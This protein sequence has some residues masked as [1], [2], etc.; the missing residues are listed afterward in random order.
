[1][2][3]KKKDTSKRNPERKKSGGATAK[4]SS[5]GRKNTRNS[6]HNRRKQQP[7][8]KGGGRHGRKPAHKQQNK[9]AQKKYDQ[10]SGQ[11]Q[12]RDEKNKSQKSGQPRQ[13]KTAD[14]KKILQDFT[15]RRINKAMA[16]GSDEKSD[17]TITA[18]IDKVDDIMNNDFFVPI[19]SRILVAVSGGV[20]SV[21]LLDILAQM[22]EK[23]NFELIVC[24][25]NH[26]LRGK[27][28]DE[29]EKYVARL[30]K[31]YGLQFL[32][33]Q[34]NV[35]K[36]AEKYSLGIE[37]A[38]RR[39]RY[40]FLDKTARSG[41]VDY[42][43]TAHNA[44]DTVE[45]FLLNLFRGAGLTGLS[46]IPEMRQIAKNLALI[47]PLSRM[48]RAEI[49]EYA[50]L[51]SLEWREDA[52]NALLIYS[53]NRIRHDLLPKL[54]KEYSPAVVDVIK[55]TA[56]LFRN[57]DEFIADYVKMGVNRVIT[58]KG[59]D[60]FAIKIGFFQTYNEFI[61][62]EI[63]QSAMRK[64]FNQQPVSLKTID[65]ILDLMSSPVG[66]ICEISRDFIVL[67]D[68]DKLIFSR[69]KP[70]FECDM[71]ID[72]IGIF[73]VGKQ[74]IIL[75]KVYKKDVK[76][77]RDPNIEYFDMDKLPKLLH[78]RRWQPGDSF[79]PV[80]FE[81]HVKVGDYLT[82]QKVSLL[83]KQNVLVLTN[84]VDIIWV[85]GFRMSD[86]YKV[87]KSTQRVIKAE[88][89]DNAAEKK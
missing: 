77:T 47:R 51:R 24:H 25:F 18:A 74:K 20:D 33:G 34:G 68:R 88:F 27:E 14:P 23:F 54:E 81:G 58:D 32:S 6:A 86:D 40:R 16:L 53:R 72:R 63:I 2:P 43:A 9:A 36:Y 64:H 67:K 83:D 41:K 38:A 37:Q 4:Q 62:G 35:R 8:K 12:Q 29:D 70:A 71:F 42:I 1:M 3:E 65:R 80:N 11:K 22:V 39:L 10:K 59:S 45:T 15:I 19:D 13:K 50:R 21:V 82:N 57:A 84:R 78:L 87:T 44:N 31:K 5:A 52:T 61:Q 28:S 79:K 66:S 75:D 89:I 60:R 46:G 76:F 85:C 69:K 17:R 48:Q 26:N 73:K 49:E 56:W 7:K 55:R 30:A